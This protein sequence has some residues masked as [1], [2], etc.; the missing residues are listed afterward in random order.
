MPLTSYHSFNSLFFYSFISFFFI[1]IFKALRIITV[2]FDKN[3]LQIFIQACVTFL[4]TELVKKLRSKSW[5]VFHQQVTGT[6]TIKFSA[7]R[8]IL[9]VVNKPLKSFRIILK[10]LWVRELVLNPI[11]APKNF[12]SSQSNYSYRFE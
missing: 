5:K 6:Y 4:P 1:L 2:R 8:V 12:L 10:R 7:L 9:I 11:L 3:L